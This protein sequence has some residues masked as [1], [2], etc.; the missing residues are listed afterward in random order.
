MIMSE[1]VCVCVCHH[2]GY[3]RSSGRGRCHAGGEASCLHAERGPGSTGTSLLHSATHE[4]HCQ[5]SGSVNRLHHFLLLPL[6]MYTFYDV[7][8]TGKGAA[9][10]D[11]L[12]NLFAGDLNPV[13]S[14]A[15]KK[16]PVPTGYVSIHCTW[17]LCWKVS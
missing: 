8:D 4:I 10:A 6:K 16:V 17:T 11:E 14:K 15:Q 12:T 13:A 5:A 3:T 7:M 9:V 2:A 1:C